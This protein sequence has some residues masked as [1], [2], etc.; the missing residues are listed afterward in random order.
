MNDRRSVHLRRIDPSQNMR[1][2]Y[3]LSVQPT[4]FG[5][6]SLVRDWGRIGTRGQSMI[7]TFDTPAEAGDAML[8]LERRKRRRGYRDPHFSLSG[9]RE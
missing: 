3:S 5:G 9:R 6:A 7:E 8:R 1:R 2:F 4:L